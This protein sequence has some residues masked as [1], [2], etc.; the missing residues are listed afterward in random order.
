VLARAE[1]VNLSADDSISVRSRYAPSAEANRLSERPA[2]RDSCVIEGNRLQSVWGL[3]E[4]AACA[5]D[6]ADRR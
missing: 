5:A 2:W 4:G 6:R 3:I 1:V